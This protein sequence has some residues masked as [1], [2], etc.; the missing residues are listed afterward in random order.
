[1][2]EKLREMLSEK[3]EEIV[4]RMDVAVEQKK[5]EAKSEMETYFKELKQASKIVLPVNLLEI[6]A[7]GGYVKVQEMDFLDDVRPVE[8][9]VEMYAPPG[10]RIFEAEMKMEPGSQY[11]VIVLIEKVKGE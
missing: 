9:R 8:Y 3:E 7:N 1:M 11:R 10:R 6:L 5:E 4:E 2:L